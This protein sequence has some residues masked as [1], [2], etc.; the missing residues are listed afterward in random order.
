MNKIWLWFFLSAKRQLKRPA[1]V[2]LLVGV[3]LLLYGVSYLEQKDSGKIAVGIYAEDAGLAKEIADTLVKKEGMLQF[4]LCQNEESLKAEVASRKAE[5]GYILPADLKEKL[6]GNKMKRSIRVYTAPSTV[7]QALSSE[8]VFAAL[9]ER[10][11]RD[12]LTD[13]VKKDELFSEF[14]GDAAA[15]GQLFDKYDQNGS[16]F[17]FAYETVGGKSANEMPEKATFPVRGMVAVYLFVIGLFS[18]VTLVQDEKKGLFIPVSYHLKIG[19]KFVSILAP[20]ALAA[21]SG[22]LAIWASG[23]L[24]AV[25]KE[26]GVLAIYVMAIALAG[27]LLKSIIKNKAILINLIPFMTLGSLILCPVFIDIGKWIPGLAVLGKFFLPYYYLLL[28]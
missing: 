10:Y 7:L 22:L 6:D 8:V 9:I 1:F 18:A 4:Y 24:T 5:C 17:S 28:F 26:V 21:C 19:S 11:G 3:P 2:V 12:L 14:H 25:G 16:T 23:N 27:Y 13:F 20:V 15:V